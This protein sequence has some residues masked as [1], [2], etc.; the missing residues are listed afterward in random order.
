VLDALVLEVLAVFAVD[1]LVV[2]L[3]VLLVLVAELLVLVLVLAAE[4][5]ELL[6]AVDVLD[7]ELVPEAPVP[8]VFEVGPL[9]PPVVLDVLDALDEREPPAECLPQPRR[10]EPRA[11]PKIKWILGSMAP[12]TISGPAHIVAIAVRSGAGQ[13]SCDQMPTRRRT[14]SPRRLATLRATCKLAP[15]SFG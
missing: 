7:D 10:S 13:R 9:E 1:A 8:D 14:F 6:V 3:F 15:M 2:V 12:R 11:S 5:V 4:L